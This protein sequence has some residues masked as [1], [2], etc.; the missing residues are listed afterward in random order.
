MKYMLDTNICIYIIKNK[1]VEVVKRFYEHYDEGLSIS[2]LTLA[3]LAHGIE[4][5][6][7]KEKNAIALINLLYFLKVI[8]FSDSAAYEYGKI[9]AYLQK[10]GTPI[11][12]MDM[13]IAAHAKANSLTIVTNNMREFARVPDLNVVNWCE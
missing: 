5:S 1:P 8:P 3:E 2:S 9:C 11:G 13:L 7:N 4:K 10:R 6:A 12:T